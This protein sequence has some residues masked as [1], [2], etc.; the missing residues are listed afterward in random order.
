MDY[1][2]EWGGPSWNDLERVPRHVKWKKQSGNDYKEYATLQWKKENIRK[3][4][5][6]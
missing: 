5:C 3:Y 4:T 2:K 6:I 1:N